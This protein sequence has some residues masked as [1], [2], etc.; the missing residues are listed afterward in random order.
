MRS[1]DCFEC[2]VSALR[3]V[4]QNLKWLVARRRVARMAK[5]KAR[6]PSNDLGFRSLVANGATQSSAPMRTATAGRSLWGP[7]LA[8]VPV[9]HE[10]ACCHAAG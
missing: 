4:V 8:L 1:S 5:N 7:G 3:A 10:W 9:G 2:E 6:R